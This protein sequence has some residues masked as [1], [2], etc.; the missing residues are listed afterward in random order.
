MLKILSQSKKILSK[1]IEDLYNEES[2]VIIGRCSDYILK[3]KSNVI[4]IFIYAS[5]KDFRLKRKA[6]YGGDDALKQL[7]E[8]YTKRANYYK[9]FTSQSWGDKSNYDICIDTS[10]LGIEGTI[11]LLEQYVRGR[12]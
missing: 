2:C 5:D 4:K 10:K 12:V 6:S 1:V 9:H 11:D 7:D 8:V 3:D